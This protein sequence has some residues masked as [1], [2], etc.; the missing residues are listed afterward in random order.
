VDERFGTVIIGGG[1]AGLS[2]GYFLTTLGQPFT[3]LEEHK[4]VGD[5]WRE[6][7]SSLRLFTPAKYDA[8][9]GMPFPAP[10]YAFP[11]GHQMADY[12]EGYAARA[13]MPVLTSVKVDGLW[14]AGDGYVVSAGGLRFTAE[15]VVVATGGPRQPSLPSF[16]GQLDPRIRQFHSSDYRAPSQLVPGDVLVVGV[17]HSGADIALEAAAEHRTWLSGPVHGQ[18][19][20]NI[21]GWA[22]RP[23]WWLLWF[24][25]NRVLTV[26][27][28]LGRKMQPT[29]RHQGGPLVRVRMP[30][31]IAAGVEHLSARTA[32]VRDGLPML[33]DGQVLD[34]TNVI[35]C[36]GF[37]HDYSWIHLPVIGEY[38]WPVHERGVVPAEPGLYFVGLPLQY[39]FTSMLVGGA[40]RDARYVARQI[41]ARREQ[42]GRSRLSPREHR[43]SETFPGRRAR[44]P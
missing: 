31:L 30:A 25:A 34:V 18:I 12:L 5:S 7:Y 14:P 8:L 3:I 35:W 37:R 26:N 16:A 17:S 21:E 23:V 1:Q 15:Q 9:P 6:R 29:D 41:A 27:T 2:V 4:C 43:S 39:A 13:P 36:T 24:A 19:P 42:R 11:S 10:P 32:G 28:P 40:G 22:A 33:E 38:G 44:T 20:F